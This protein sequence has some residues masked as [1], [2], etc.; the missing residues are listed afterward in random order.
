MFPQPYRTYVRIQGTKGLCEYA[1][2]M[3][4]E[5]KLC[6]QGDH[7]WEP[8][9]PYRV[10]YLADRAGVPEEARSIGH[11]SMEYWMMKAWA[12]ALRDGRPLPIDV[13]R[14]MDYT[15]PCIL[16]DASARRNGE[17]LAVPDSRMWT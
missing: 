3:D 14:A 10:R 4:A 6:L 5:P 9:E 13:H 15:L 12:D 16:A 8:A 1:Y 7:R 2:G 11:G 17:W